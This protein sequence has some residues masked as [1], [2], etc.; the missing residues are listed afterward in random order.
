MIFSWICRFQFST[1][2]D[3]WESGILCFIAFSGIK[4]FGSIKSRKVSSQS[5]QS[6][7]LMEDEDRDDGESV[8]SD[9]VEPTEAPEADDFSLCRNMPWVRVGL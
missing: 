5:L 7:K 3:F 9:E 8:M 6:D 4:R 1:K 2:L